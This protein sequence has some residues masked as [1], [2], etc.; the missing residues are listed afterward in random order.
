MFEHI[1]N[2]DLESCKHFTKQKII[3]NWKVSYNL[4]VCKFFYKSNKPQR[5]ATFNDYFKYVTD[6]YFVIRGKLELDKLRCQWHMQLMYEN[7]KVQY[8]INMV[9][10]SFRNMK[11]TCLK[12]FTAQCKNKLLKIFFFF[13]HVS[14][15]QVH[16]FC[17]TVVTSFREVLLQWRT[18]KIYM[19]G[20]FSGMWWSFVFG[21]C[22]SWRHSL[23]TYSCF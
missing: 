21:V 7:V 6:V 5:R 15:N 4:G 3:C 2:C 19:G 13:L 17:T 16:W 12:L 18:Q 9:T 8:N 1:W 11:Y 23:T 14:I 20:S 22:C 10:N